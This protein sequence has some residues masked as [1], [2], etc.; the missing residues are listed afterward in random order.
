MVSWQYRLFSGLFRV[1]PQSFKIKLLYFRRFKRLPNLKQPQTFNEK[2]NWRKLNERD[3]LFAIAADKVASKQWVCDL[4]PWVKAPETLWQGTHF[5]SFDPTSLPEKYVVKGNHGSRMNLFFD[6]E[7]QPDTK[8][9]E[10]TRKKWFKHDQYSTLGEWGYKHIKKQVFA[11]EFLDFNGTAPDDYKFFVYHGR[12]HFV[13]LDSGRFQGHHRN[14]FDRDWRDLDVEFSHPKLTPSPTKPELYEQMVKAAEKIGQHFSFVRVDFYQYQG[15]VY[16]GE[17]TLY[18]GAGYEVFPSD[19]VDRLFGEPWVV[20]KSPVSQSTK[21]KLLF[22]VNVDWFF[23]SHRLPI[24]L[25]AIEAGYEV[26]LAAHDTGDF[27]EFERQGIVCHSVPF[28]RSGTNPLAELKTLKKLMSV[29]RLVQ[30]DVT[31]TVTIKPAIYTG[32]L[33]KLCRIPAVVFA[34]SGLGL[35][36][37]SKGH[38]VKRAVIKS[39]YRWALSHPNKKIIFQNEQD[40]QT[41][42]SILGAPKE[43]AVRVRGSGADLSEFSYSEEPNVADDQPVT[44]V[45][46]AR[47][48][49]DKGVYDFVES[50]KRYQTLYKE[51]TS[52]INIGKNELPKLRFCLIGGPD[53]ENPHSVSLAEFEQW[54]HSSYVDAIGPQSNIAEHFSASHIVVLPSY[55]GEGLPKV[56]IEAAACGRPIVTT[57]N[58]GCLAAV[59]P[60]ETGLVV[61]PRDTDS[62]LNAIIALA[63]DT[64]KRKAFGQKARMLAERDFDVNAVVATHLALYEQVSTCSDRLIERNETSATDTGSTS[65]GNMQ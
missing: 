3:P 49:K 51:A 9:L 38:G 63:K 34:I 25:A 40:E 7:T 58:P 35:M 56:L 47:L 28:S 39:L 13:Q 27:G 12:V 45:M 26:H 43:V 61:E 36:F 29:L 42:M 46:A 18:P 41:L 60:N 57:N 32:L 1:L 6:A 22:V 30:P 54:Q 33:S 52:G 10:Q 50:A 55:Y 65:T 31:H 2:V 17:L 59:I 64:Q 16:F 5:D 14:L 23:K 44:V 53:L 4:C 20:A 15:A 21:P 62:L 11:E 19:D 48:L 8:A 37:S 24:A